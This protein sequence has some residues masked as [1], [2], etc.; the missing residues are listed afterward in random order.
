MERFKLKGKGGKRGV[1]GFFRAW[2]ILRC[3]FCMGGRPWQMDKKKYGLYRRVC[4]FFYP[5]YSA[6][7]SPCL[8]RNDHNNKWALFAEIHWKGKNRGER[9]GEWRNM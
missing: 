6:K 5:Y 2:F 7:E 9:P 8:L 3:G 4:V 1:P